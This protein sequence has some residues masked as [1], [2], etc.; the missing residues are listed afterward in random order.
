[1]GEAQI[2]ADLGKTATSCGT[3]QRFTRV[4]TSRVFPGRFFAE[5]CLGI[6]APVR[7]ME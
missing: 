6:N 3:L 2:G 4:V 7:W 5:I 1:M